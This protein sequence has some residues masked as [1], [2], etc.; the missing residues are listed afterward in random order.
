MMEQLKMQMIYFHQLQNQIQLE[1]RKKIKLIPQMKTTLK[2]TN[3]KNLVKM[4]IV[5]MT[6][7]TNLKE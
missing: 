2:M 4:Q 6:T 7:A 3:Q 1:L 5:L